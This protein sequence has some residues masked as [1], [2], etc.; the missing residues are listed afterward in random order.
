MRL[1]SRD[2]QRRLRKA[3]PGLDVKE[4]RQGFTTP[5][6]RTY[7]MWILEGL[8]HGYLNGVLEETGCRPSAGR[9]GRCSR[10]V[11]PG[12]ASPQRGAAGGRPDQA[13]S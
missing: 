10:H 11:P 1:F 5:A 2:E 12:R 3:I 9:G 8:P 7:S 13:L 4:V 6:E